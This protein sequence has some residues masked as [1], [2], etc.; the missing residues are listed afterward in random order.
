MVKRKDGFVGERSIVLPP[1]V[2]QME[3]DDPLVSSLY[4]TDIGHY[5]MAE[6]H[7]RSRKDAIDQYVLIYCVDGSG[8]YQL[9]G[10]RHEVEKDQYF[11]LPAGLPHEYGSTEGSKWT[12][13]WVHFSGAH[14]AIYS[15]GAQEPQTV[16]V[17]LSSRISNRNNIFEEIL[18]A[19]HFGKDIEDLRYASSLLHYY[20]ASLRYL[21][22]YRSNARMDNSQ[23]GSLLTTGN[24]TGVVDAAIHFMRENIERRITLLDVVNYVGYSSS[25]FSALFKKETGC[26]PLAYFNRLK[27]E[28]AC[29]LLKVTDLH[30]NQICFKVG[31]ED[32]LYFSRLFSKT[33]GMPPR[34]W[35]Q[36]SKKNN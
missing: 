26:S 33:M 16:S 36:A 20:L 21:R 3:Q 35:R 9:K 6:H 25:H 24:E 30:I 2:I 22:Q 34:E 8:W 18:A 17:S 10:K 19:L 28:H 15:E 4:V 31:F 29:H 13:Y 12:I 32:S 11:I 27:I 23:G 1:M 14:A 5:P 7:Y